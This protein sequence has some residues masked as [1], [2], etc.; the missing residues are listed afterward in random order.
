ML[1]MFREFVG[2]R[3][4]SHENYFWLTFAIFIIYATFFVWNFRKKSKASMPSLVVYGTSC[5]GV[6]IWAAAY[7]IWGVVSEAFSVDCIWYN[8]SLGIIYMTM[9]VILLRRHKRSCSNVS[10]LRTREEVQ[11]TS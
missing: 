1:E 3:N 2:F 8:S 5:F 6:A 4:S 9:A 11:W 10:E 7:E